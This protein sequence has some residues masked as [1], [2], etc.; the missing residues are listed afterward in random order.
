VK[1]VVILW[2]KGYNKMAIK[3]APENERNAFAVSFASDSH[4]GTLTVKSFLQHIGW[5]ATDRLALPTTWNAAEKMFEVTLPMKFLG[6][7]EKTQPKK[8]VFR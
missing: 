1:T 4:A 3:A 5:R 6:T 8:R 2:D 7:E